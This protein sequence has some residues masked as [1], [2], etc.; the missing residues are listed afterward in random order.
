MEKIGGVY[1]LF[2]KNPLESIEKCHFSM[3]K[4]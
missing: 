1:E 2:I 4:H 3:K